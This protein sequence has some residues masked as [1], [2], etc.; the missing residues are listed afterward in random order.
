MIINNE[1]FRSLKSMENIHKKDVG[2]YRGY[3]VELER[4]FS[5]AI[6]ICDLVHNVETIH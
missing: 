5:I 1:K 2:P 4:T 3:V 6:A